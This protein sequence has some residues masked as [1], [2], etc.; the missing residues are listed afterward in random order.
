MSQQLKDLLSQ[1][2]R[3]RD[4]LEWVLGVVYRT[5]GPCYRKAGAMMLFNSLGQQFGMLSGGCLESDIQ[6][7]AQQVM[8]TGLNKSLCYDG[9]DEDDLSFQLGIGCGGTVYLQLQKVDSN[10]GYLALDLLYTSLQKHQHGIYHVLI[11]ENTTPAARFEELENPTDGISRLLSIEGND[12]L[13]TPITPP[14]HLLLIGGGLDARPLAALAGE[15]GWRQSLWDPRPAN[16]RAA[17]FPAVETIIDADVS[18]L[19]DFY[20]SESV[21]ATVLMSHNVDLDAKALQ[22]LPETTVRYIALLGPDSR[23]QK[24]LKTAAIDERDLPCPLAG[25]AGLRLGG[26][27]PESIALAMLAEC[28]AALFGKN[29]ASI[30]QVL[31]S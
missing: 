27:L 14:P 3:Q 6:R 21:D 4:S 9:S 7:Y 23:K 19:N 22:A 17:Y 8:Q 18:A 26:E 13:E 12:W 25:P 24:V 1:W 29:A 10:N 15:L 16:G 2:Y 11:K 31:A 28:H 5:E 20:C 30:S